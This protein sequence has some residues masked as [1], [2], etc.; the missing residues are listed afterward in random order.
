MDFREGDYSVSAG[1]GR[2][3]ADA[4]VLRTRS[5]VART[6]L[7]VLTEE[8]SDA[9]THARVAEIAGFS[10]T[11]LYAHWPSRLD[12]AAAALD[13]LG[14]LPSRERTGDLRTDLVDQLTSFRQGV[15]DHR[16]DRVL[17]AM[18]Q[19]AT[20]EA[21]NEVRERINTEGQRPLRAILEGAFHGARLEAI[22]SMLSG[23]VACPAL[24]FGTVPDDDVIAAAVDIVLKTVR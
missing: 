7:A 2:K 17:A 18:A 10:K 13:I 16:L 4:R 8:G 23:V 1:Q 19:W 14:E 3:A 24:M 11:T 21:M 9:L 5:E 15:T 20:I 22:V 6:A 12:L